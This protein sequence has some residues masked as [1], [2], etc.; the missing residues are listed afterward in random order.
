M[1]ALDAAVATV[2]AATGPK[3]I[4]SLATVS[5]EDLLEMHQYLGPYVQQLIG[6][7]D[8]SSPIAEYLRRD[9]INSPEGMSLVILSEVVAELR[10]AGAVK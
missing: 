10:G 7:A 8:D 4:A 3:I 2:L 9:G 6:L 1:N 5:D